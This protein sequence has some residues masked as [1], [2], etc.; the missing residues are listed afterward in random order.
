[1]KKAVFWGLLFFVPFLSCKKSKI[2]TLY[3]V[4]PLLQKEQGKE[5]ETFSNVVGHA[6]YGDT[7]AWS[8]ASWEDAREGIFTRRNGSGET[9]RADVTGYF[10]QD[11][12]TLDFR[13][14]QRGSMMV[15]CDL[16]D[17][18]CGWRN[19]GVPEN[20]PLM[21]VKIRFAPWRT[22][23]RYEDMRWT[24][25]KYSLSLPVEKKEQE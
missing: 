16:T 12:T 24:M 5:D 20:L 13:L 1:M 3:S 11:G 22:N 17:S 25:V 2:D 7:T 14:T 6:I 4:T 18:I 19:V 15:V 21:S 23:D 8:V 9:R 10:S